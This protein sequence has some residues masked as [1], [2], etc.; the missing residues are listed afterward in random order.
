MPVFE[1]TKHWQQKGVT[2]NHSPHNWKSD[3]SLIKEIVDVDF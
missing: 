1:I 2:Q 3:V